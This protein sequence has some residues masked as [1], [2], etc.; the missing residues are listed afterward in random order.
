[1]GLVA[2]HSPLD[3]F[4]VRLCRRLEWLIC[5]AASTLV[6]L[7]GIDFGR[8]FVIPGPWLKAPETFLQSMM[9]WDGGYF[10]HIVEHVALENIAGHMPGWW[11][12]LDGIT[13]KE[14]TN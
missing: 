7:L 14:I 9:N 10:G 4:I 12:V 2:E 11:H 13:G 3:P 8:Q 1:M 6:V 5:F